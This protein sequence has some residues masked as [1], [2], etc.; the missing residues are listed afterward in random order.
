[1]RNYT[2]KSGPKSRWTINELVLVKENWPDVQGIAH[3]LGRTYNAVK[4]KGIELKLPSR[5]RVG[6]KPK[7]IPKKRPDQP[8]FW[9][10]NDIATIRSMWPDLRSIA[11]Q[12]KRTHS[13]VRHMAHKLRLP[14]R[15]RASSKVDR[16]K[17]Y[18]RIAS[19]KDKRAI[20]FLWSENDERILK[21]LW[22]DTSFAAERLNRTRRAVRAKAIKLNLGTRYRRGKAW[23]DKDRHD[24]IYSPD[25]LRDIAARL[26]RTIKAVKTVRNTHRRQF[27]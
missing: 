6:R 10:D 19:N 18:T 24:A 25:P 20:E 2:R 8:H 17:K 21:E 1:M 7:Y 12:L 27:R 15:T 22:P 4:H 26:G 11:E 14:N 9:T 23:V 13:A 16:P 3:L 5:K